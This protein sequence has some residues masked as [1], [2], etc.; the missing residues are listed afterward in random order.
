MTTL[1]KIQLRTVRSALSSAVFFTIL[2][3]FLPPILVSNTGMEQER[4]LIIILLPFFLSILVKILAH[5]DIYKINPIWIKSNLV[6]LIVATE[7][8]YALLSLRVITEWYTNPENQFMEPL[9]VALALATTYF[10]RLRLSVNSINTTT[11]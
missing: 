3:I 11:S 2:F 7:A 4:F 9:F 5:P 1:E 10:E 6:S 8:A